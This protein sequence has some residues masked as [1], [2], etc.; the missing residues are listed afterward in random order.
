MKPSIEELDRQHPLT[1][2]I[3]QLSCPVLYIHSHDD[4][5]SPIGPIQEI[6][7]VTHHSEN[8]WLDHSEHGCHHLKHKSTYYQQLSAFITRCLN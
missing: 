6:Q 4:N 3:D 8:L 2:E 5:L 1:K 7:K